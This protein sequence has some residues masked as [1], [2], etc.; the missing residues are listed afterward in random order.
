MQQSIRLA[1]R[2]ADVPPYSVWTEMT[3]L[4][5]KHGAVNLGQGFPNFPPPDFLLKEAHRV[6]DESV[7][8]PTNQQYA[9]TQ[10]N[11]EL[12]SELKRIYAKHLGWPDIGD[13]NIVITNGTTQGLNMVFQAIVNP[14]DEVITF[15]PFYDAYQ[16][17]IQLAGG[18]VRFVQMIPGST[19]L[20]DSWTFSEEQL[21]SLINPRTK[22]ILVNT[23]QNVPGKAWTREEMN[24]VAS[25]AL[26]HNLIVVSDEVYMHLV[27]ATPHPIEGQKHSHLSIAALPDMRD[28]CVTLCSSG[29]TFSATGWK[30]GW[31]VGPTKLIQALS[32]LELYQTFNVATPLQIATARGLRI[33]EEVGYY[34]NLL[35]QYEKRRKLLCDMLA[36]NNLPP[37]IPSG[38]FFVLA[39]ISLVDPKHYLDPNERSVGR[40]WQFCRWLT[41]TLKVCAI[42]VTAFCQKENRPVYDKFVRFAYCKKEEDIIEAGIRLERLSEYLLPAH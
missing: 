5:N 41:R 36:K 24:I 13:E 37:T 30:I 3:P 6:F 42:P 11:L 10:G 38:G 23:P 16:C 7:V 14:G 31:A 8:T 34:E 29:K 32:L 2:L 18:V 40:D 35:S 39:D 27:Y 26:E 4:A 22:A 17:D 15:E 9:R 1:D 28:R 21:R 25:L 20:A 33:A 19:G 12:V